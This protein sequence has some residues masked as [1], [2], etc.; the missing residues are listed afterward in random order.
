MPLEHTKMPVVLNGLG[1]LTPLFS[2][3]L[4]KKDYEWSPVSDD[5][6]GDYTALITD[7]K[8]VAELERLFE[9]NPLIKN[10]LVQYF[11]REGE[12]MRLTINANF[13]DL[14]VGAPRTS[15][16]AGGR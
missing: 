5:K 10:N 2:N 11:E 9:A 3:I 12:G 6:A 4:K 15:G 7:P 14:A 13:Y 16:L 1:I 8:D